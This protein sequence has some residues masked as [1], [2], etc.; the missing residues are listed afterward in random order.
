MV[1][2]RGHPSS[3]VDRRPF[4]VWLALSVAILLGFGLLAIYSAG[5][6]PGSSDY[7]AKQLVFAVAGLIPLLL[8]WKIDYRWWSRASVGLYVLNLLLLLSVLAIGV[9]R[10]GAR[11][12]IELGGF[13]FQPSELCKLILVLT[14]SAFYAK[15]QDV[16][17]R[18]GTFLLSIAHVL[19]P[20][21]MVFLEPHLGATLVLVAIWVTISLFAG[22]PIRYLA[23][24]ALLLG[25]IAGIA[26]TAPGVLKPYQR[27]RVIGMF[28]GDQQGKG[29]QPY[30]AVLAIGSGGLMG[31][32]FL[33]GE[34]KRGGYI[35]DQHTDF[36][37]TVIG[38]EGGLVG[39][40]ILL[41]A[42]ALL[43]Y[44]IWIVLFMAREPPIRMMA[45]G[46]LGLLGFHTVANL[47]MNLQ[48]L[49]VV[50]L[51]LPFLS[52]GGTA[53]WLCM[54]CVGLVLNLGANEKIQLF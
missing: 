17:T 47:G 9:E 2:A 26:W 1:D 4:D 54:A 18:P 11:R 19:P 20:I 25:L 36:I 37:F 16:I 8:F 14:L 12:W 21:L 3:P 43:F 42:Y 48:L 33:K 10:N 23:Y 40:A 22:V 31:E 41:G 15:R 44:R 34:Q 52:Y 28:E 51:W 53:L 27:A 39:C 5:M 6:R 49:P 13:Q 32:G 30:R 46:V 35:P 50:G 45:A 29:Y 24:T 38:E 7:F